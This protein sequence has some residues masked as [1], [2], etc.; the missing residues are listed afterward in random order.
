MSIVAKPQTLSLASTRFTAALERRVLDC[1]RKHPIFTAGEHVL[2]GV[3]GGP[4]STALLVVLSRLRP[5]LQIDLTAAHFDHMLRTRREAED[6]ASFVGDIAEALG[7]PLI[8]GAGDVR[9]SARSN[10]HSIEYAARRLRYAFL[11]E[12]ALAIGTSCI[13]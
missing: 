8:T 13:S 11:G 5:K 4:D 10:H 1:V 9:D 2:V 3:S 12:Q 7:M 6:D